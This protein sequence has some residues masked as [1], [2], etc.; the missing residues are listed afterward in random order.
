VYLPFCPYSLCFLLWKYCLC[1]YPKYPNKR[2]FY[3]LCSP[4]VCYCR[5]S[6]SS[7]SQRWLLFHLHGTDY[8]GSEALAVDELLQVDGFERRTRCA[9]TDRI[10][11]IVEPSEPESSSS[12]VQWSRMACGPTFF[13]GRRHRKRL[14]WWRRRRR[15]DS[16]IALVGL[17]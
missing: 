6:K 12:A 15:W 3:V 8:E 13:V 16:G 9:G 1:L 17:E 2:P 5:P 10:G 14:P 4:R 11:G 7:R